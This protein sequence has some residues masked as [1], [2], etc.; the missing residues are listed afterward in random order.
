MVRAKVRVRRR[1]AVYTIRVNVSQGEDQDGG[2]RERDGTG[3]EKRTLHPPVVQQADL[4]RQRQRHEVGQA[5]HAEDHGQE[6]EGRRLGLEGA[7][8]GQAH[9]LA[10]QVDDSLVGDRA[11]VGEEE[12]G[13]CE[14][15][16]A[17]RGED[18]FGRD[19][20]HGGWL[21]GIRGVVASSV[22]RVEEGPWKPASLWRLEL[23]YDD[24]G[25]GLTGSGGSGRLLRETACTV[26]EGEGGFDAIYSN[27]SWI[28][29]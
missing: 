12:E 14:V 27:R 3:R 13:Q 17:E 5:D 19:E 28:W 22:V 21:L 4:V 7:R 15:E 6:G 10:Q 2:R 8:V 29:Q 23:R 24:T 26:L 9:R 18:G 1:G 16:E 20:R 11:G 25:R